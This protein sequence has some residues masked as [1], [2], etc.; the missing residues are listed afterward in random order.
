[1][2]ER[3]A[4]LNEAME[5]NPDICAIS[6]ILNDGFSANRES[7]CLILYPF[8]YWQ[9]LSPENFLTAFETYTL[10]V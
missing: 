6:P 2:M 5:L 7:E 8:T 9:K 1:M 3:N 10:F 4:M